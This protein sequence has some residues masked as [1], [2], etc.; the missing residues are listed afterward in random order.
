MRLAPLSSRALIGHTERVHDFVAELLNQPRGYGPCEAL[1]FLDA[2][3][4]LVAG[5]VYH[6]YQPEYGR[7]EI[8]AAALDHGLGTRG[9]LRLVFSYPFDQLGC[10]LVIARMN[11]NN[12]IP[13]R[14]WRALGAEEY[15]IPRLRGRNV[16]EILATLTVENWRAKWA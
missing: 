8:T 1:G 14:I 6:D 7:I 12:P 15:R 16:A 9:R 4:K 3:G 10:Q 2:D 13:L 11:E 5:I